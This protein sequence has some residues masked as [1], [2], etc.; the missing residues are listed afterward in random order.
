MHS[1]ILLLLVGSVP[2]FGVGTAILNPVDL[3]VV[4]VEL[5]TL[6]RSC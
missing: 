5:W 1:L 3:Q 4:Q 2:D 6:A